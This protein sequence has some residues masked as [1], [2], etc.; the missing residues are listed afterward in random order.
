MSDVKPTS[1]KGN[2]PATVRISKQPDAVVLAPGEIPTLNGTRFPVPAVVKKPARFPQLPGFEI[3]GELGRGGMGVVYKAKQ[4]RL[5]RIVALKMLLNPDDSD[6]SDVIRFRSEAEAVAAVKH[7]HIVQVHEFGLH[8]GL[9]F[10]T[11]EFLGGGTLQARIQAEAPFEPRRAAKLV[12]KLARAVHAAHSQ[13]I[14]HR[15]LKPGN[16]LFDTAGEPRVTDFGLAKR[17]SHQLTRTQAVMGTPGYMPPEQAAGNAKSVGPGADIYALGVMLYECL[18][19]QR[20]FAGTDSMALLHQVIHDPPASL[21][22]HDRTLPRDIDLICLKCLEKNPNDRY[23]TAAALADDLGRFV[24][25][26]PVSVRPAGPLERTFKWAKRRPTL[27]AAYSLALVALVFILLFSGALTLWRSAESERAA[28][29]ELRKKAQTAERDIAQQKQ[30]VVKVNGQ[31]N[32]ANRE[33]SEKT[34]QLVKEQGELKRTLVELDTQKQKA[35]AAVADLTAEKLRAVQLKYYRDINMARKELNERHFLRA[36]DLIHNCPAELRGWEWW[37]V[38]KAARQE[39][40]A[41]NSLHIPW[42]AAFD[43]AT[44]VNVN[45]CDYKGILTRFDFKVGSGLPQQLHPAGDVN[46]MKISANG[47]RAFTLGANLLHPSKP[48]ELTVWNA[49]DGSAVAQWVT[50]ADGT[51]GEAISGS[52]QRIVYAGANGTARAFDV[53]SGKELPKLTGVPFGP[54]SLRLGESGAIALIP[55]GKD[56][57]VWELATGKILKRLPLPS[58]RVEVTA[59]GPDD[60]LVAHGTTSGDLALEYLDGSKPAVRIRKAHLGPL[61]NI[62]FHADRR[63]VA[64][65]GDDGAVRI[66][67]LADGT[68]HREYVGHARRVRGLNFNAKGNMLVSSDEDFNFRVWW[69][70]GPKPAIVRFDPVPQTPGRLVFDATARRVFATGVD[71]NA[72][73]WPNETTSHA[74]LAPEDQRILSASF[75]PRKEQ[76]AFGTDKGYL[77]IWNYPGT[78][79]LVG[80][81]NGST[82]KVQYSADGTRLLTARPGLVAVWDVVGKRLLKQWD[83]SFEDDNAAMSS[84][85]KWIVSGAGNTLIGA[86]VDDDRFVNCLVEDHIRC[87]GFTPDDREFVVGTRNWRLQTYPKETG[88]KHTRN[89][90]GHT[91]AI[92][93]FAF[94]PDGK[95]LA[96]GGQDGSV[97]VWDWQS[98]EEVIGLSLEDKEPVTQLQFLPGKGLLAWS[99]TKRPILFDGSPGQLSI[100]ASRD[101]APKPKGK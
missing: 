32:G 100:F 74:L 34:K 39:S 53:P 14:V 27:A 48:F 41:G 91:T 33:L 61:S 23:P 52:G 82:A 94:G 46:A 26:E 73:L 43:P 96:T 54:W 6:P 79:M 62:A 1:S 77:Y 18:T 12:E 44:G 83:I 85:G 17:F 25:R 55:H 16:V 60:N 69:V 64:T 63:L 29:E 50:T 70:D 11:M 51:C 38:Y 92:R 8:E 93:S 13:G 80:D 58:S 76:I 66:W 15:D 59:V 97:K 98:Q 21:R 30:E 20:P 71:R 86:S 24:S 56:L 72:G 57:A 7:P 99:A 49:R 9:P 36:I 40:G 75:H 88:A 31:L 47:E 101:D 2:P 68:L 4:L 67:N 37:H 65:A 19:G 90:K 84:D 81:L 28:A 42:D 45:T 22:S 78:P 3:L 5:S 35:E 10:F 95:Q 89:F 87:V